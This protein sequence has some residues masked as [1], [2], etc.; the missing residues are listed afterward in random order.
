MI[1]S[2]GS[3]S[4]GAASIDFAQC[5]PGT[6][7][8]NSEI[9][10]VDCGVGTYS[11][12]NSSRVCTQCPAGFFANQS[13]SITCTACPV[14]SRQPE[15]GHALISFVLV[16]FLSSCCLLFLREVSH[17]CIQETIRA[18]RVRSAGIMNSLVAQSVLSVLLARSNL[19]LAARR[20][21]NV[22]EEL[23]SLLLVQLFF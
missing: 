8:N 3:L 18:S 19:Q 12:L 15:Q 11:A 7:Q 20:V 10:C 17:C 22:L 21:H 5:P 13:N 9:P 23:L 2:G 4:V 14:G 6:I 16:F 1:Q